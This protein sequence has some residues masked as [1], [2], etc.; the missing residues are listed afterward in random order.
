MIHYLELV[1]AFVIG[2][3][4]AWII[5]PRIFLL[6]FRLRLFDSI[7][8]RKIHVRITPRLG[9]IAFSPSIIVAVALVALLHKLLTG[10]DLFTTDHALNIP[11]LFACL[12]MVYLMGAM[13]DLIG[14][15]YR[16]KLLVQTVCGIVMVASGCYIDNLCGLFGLTVISPWVGMP[17][18]VVI[19]VYIMNAFNFIDG[20]DGLATSLALIAFVFIGVMLVMAQW[21]LYACLVAATIGVLSLFFYY[22]VF[23]EPHRKR[24]IF[25][26]DTGSLTIGLLITALALGLGRSEALKD[27]AVPDALFVAFS[28]LIVPI[29]DV[30]R[31]VL[32]RVRTGNNPF[33]PDRNHIH[34]KFMAL[35]FSSARSVVSI[36]VMALG[37]ALM[38]LGLLRVVS[39]TWLLLIDIALWSL[40]HVL[41]SLRIGLGKRKDGEHSASWSSSPGISKNEEADDSPAVAST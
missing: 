18:S 4:L 2:I 24:K 31:V 19:F 38:N 14:V 35:G 16:A 34:H 9:G 1:V 6:S 7:N 40:M 39:V 36:T 13:D 15:R 32:H 37:F 17:L 29:F 23:G 12:F 3:V 21:W 10:Y 11:S 28:V 27:A 8:F 25:M 5:I 20:M 33:L 22:N 41:M 26:G 30:A